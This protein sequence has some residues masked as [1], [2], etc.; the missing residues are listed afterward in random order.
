MAEVNKQK[1]LVLELEMKIAGG[2][3]RACSCQ[4]QR[5][6]SAV[7]S[8]KKEN[9]N[10]LRNTLFLFPLTRWAVAHL[11]Q[12]PLDAHFRPFSFE[13]RGPPLTSESLSEPRRRWRE[14]GT[15][16]ETCQTGKRSRGS[17]LKI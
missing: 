15:E 5:A 11:P 13:F 1:I 4:S 9:S 12:S 10:C 16:K 6:K 3:E 14:T 2:P 7:G 17:G 8:K